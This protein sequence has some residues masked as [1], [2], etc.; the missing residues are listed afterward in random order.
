MISWWWLI[1]MAPCA[2]V[3]GYLIACRT[4]A[5]TFKRSIDDPKSPVRQLLDPMINVMATGTFEKA[6]EVAEAHQMVVQCPQNC[7]GTI[8]KGVREVAIK[9]RM[10]QAMGL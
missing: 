9:M 3:L 6:A 5:R 7:G 2:F 10:G 4:V 1:I 8:A